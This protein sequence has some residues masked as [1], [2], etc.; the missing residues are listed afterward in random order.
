[1]KPVFWVFV[2]TF[3]QAVSWALFFLS[4]GKEIPFLIWFC[5]ESTHAFSFSFLKLFFLNDKRK[6]VVGFPKLVTI[7]TVQSQD[8]NQTLGFWTLH[9]WKH[10]QLEFQLAF[11]KESLECWERIPPNRKP[12]ISDLKK[13]WCFNCLN[14][15][16]P[17]FRGVNPL[18]AS[19]INA[20]TFC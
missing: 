3:L 1:M 19:Q 15:N 17:N 18:R 11:S 20:N 14:F 2:V 7:I 13:R 8:I 6:R 9:G 5:T 10:F 12:G 16:C 4:Q